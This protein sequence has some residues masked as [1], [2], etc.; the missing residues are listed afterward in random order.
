MK[1]KRVNGT[2]K[3]TRD[4]GIEV[5]IQLSECKESN[6]KWVARYA[7]DDSSDNTTFAATKRQ[8]VEDELHAN[9]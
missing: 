8:L 9:R 1:F 4:D 6:F 5:T 7:G 2:Y 3:A